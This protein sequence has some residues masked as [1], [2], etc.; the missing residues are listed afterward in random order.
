MDVLAVSD[1][2]SNMDSQIWGNSEPRIVSTYMER[3][4][5]TLTVSALLMR[6]LRCPILNAVFTRHMPYYIRTGQRFS[7]IITGTLQSVFITY[8]T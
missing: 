6:G 2:I 7:A 5:L 1:R 8:G 4:R 3:T